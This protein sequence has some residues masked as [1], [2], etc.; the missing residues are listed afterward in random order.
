MSLNR[1]RGYVDP[2]NGLV[3][4][5]G[6]VVYAGDPKMMQFNPA[7]AKL[8]PSDLLRSTGCGHL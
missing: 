8:P 1:E 3:R 5:R 6:R 7:G 2:Q 4:P